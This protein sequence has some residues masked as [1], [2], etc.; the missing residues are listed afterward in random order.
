MEKAKIIFNDEPV[1]PPDNLASLN[2][3][4]HRRLRRYCQR[5]GK[6]L[7]SRGSMENQGSLVEATVTL[8]GPND[9]TI[10]R[11][12][13]GRSKKEASDNAA[14]EVLDVFPVVSKQSTPTSA[15]KERHGISRKPSSLFRELE[16][17]AMVGDACLDLLITM[18]GAEK[19]LSCDAIDHV[20]QTVVSNKALSHGQG[21]KLATKVES[22]VGEQLMANKQVLMPFLESAI[23]PEL[24]ESI[25]SGLE[26]MVSS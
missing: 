17:F 3:G 25:R 22:I 11:T 7:L 1:L 15:L 9:L 16:V 19:R 21:R 14:A 8:V 26:N 18:I 5:S 10:S 20:R 6:C 23:G 4:A 24:S 12:A 2:A 13:L